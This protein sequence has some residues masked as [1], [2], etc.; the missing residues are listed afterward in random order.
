MATITLTANTN[1]S[2]LSVANG[3]TI[4]L[5][6]FVLTLDVQPTETD[7]QVTTPGTSGN[8]VFSSAW[9]LSTWDFFAGTGATG[10][11]ISSLPSGSTIRSATGGTG[12]NSICVTTN[13]GAIVTVNG[14]TGNGSRGVTT[15]N[16]TI[17]TANGGSNGNANGVTTNNGTVTTANG[18]TNTAVGVFINNGTV[19]TANGGSVVNSTGV[20]TNNGTVTTANGGT[21]AT[22]YGIITNNGLCL[23]LSDSTGRGVNEWRGSRCFVEGPHIAGVIPNN[24][25]TVYSLGTLSGSATIANDA[26]VITL[27]EGGTKFPPIGPGGLVF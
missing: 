24:I 26:T 1:Y 13:N 10:V 8:V 27:S 5:A 19:T 23:R 21:N 17:T 15:N 20:T 3:D 2:A 7:V 18:G 16:G 4:D 14:G 9:D 11:L 6:G 12:T 22:A 25:K